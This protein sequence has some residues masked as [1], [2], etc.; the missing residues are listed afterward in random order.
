MRSETKRMTGEMLATELDLAG[1]HAQP[2]EREEALYR[3]FQEALYNVTKHARATWVRVRL[4]C[5]DEHVVLQVTDDGVG[6]DPDA[7]T[8]GRD[9]PGLGRG[10]MAERVERLGGVLCTRSKP[11]SGAAV[12]ALVPIQETAT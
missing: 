1:Y 6:F 3:V 4:D 12:E 11:G 9:R 2:F 8:S 5:R 7:S 10:M